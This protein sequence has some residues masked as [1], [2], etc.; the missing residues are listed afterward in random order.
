[1]SEF[2]GRLGGVDGG[3]CIVIVGSGRSVVGV[4]RKGGFGGSVVVLTLGFVGALLGGFG[5]S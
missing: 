5:A 4:G 1:V 3:C 2:V